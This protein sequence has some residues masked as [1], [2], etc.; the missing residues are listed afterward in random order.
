MP[1][2]KP[3]EAKKPATVQVDSLA[4]WIEDL[5]KVRVKY[6]RD[7]AVPSGIRLRPGVLPEEGGV[8]AFWWT[9]ERNL[10]KMATC[11][12]DIVLVGP[13][14]RPVALHIDDHWLRLESES[15]IPLYVGKNADSMAKRAG[16]HLCLGQKRIL[17]LG[18]KAE[19]AKARTTSCQLRA[20]I[21]H[22][23]PHESDTRS[24][25]LNNVGFSYV[26]LDGDEHAANRFYL[27]DRAIGTMTPPF[28]I[29]VER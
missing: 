3:T 20:G 8:Y 17:P 11:N 12:R 23:F 7:V 5:Q 29:D 1:D 26:L 14:G 21:D 13:R 15:P 10:L 9:G 2:A 25:T 6:L 16:L 24:L 4:L 18:K 28:N 22:M 27:E 19:K